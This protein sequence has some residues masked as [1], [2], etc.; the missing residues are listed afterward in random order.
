MNPWIAYRVPPLTA[1][2][3][4][5]FT[6]PYA[7]GGAS[8]YRDWTR[9]LPG[10]IDV[11]PVQLPGREMRIA[12]T[13]F[14]SMAPLVSALKDGISPLLDRPF[15]LFG[16]SMGASIALELARALNS[17]PATTSVPMT[18]LIVS[19]RICPGRPPKRPPIHR[20][21]DRDFIRELGGLGGTAAEVLSSTELMELMLPLLRADFAL[22]ETYRA[23]PMPKLS[24]PILALY[25]TRDSTTEV[26][27]MEGWKQITTGDARLEPIEGDHFYLMYAKAEVTRLVATFLA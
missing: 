24:V 15:A 6:L 3:L 23:G 2:R 20:L 10:D 11:C 9:Y 4:R 25:G 14:T 7:G 26:Q 16:H 12:E 8:V 21:Q 17:D 1:P 18:G 5:L 27:D 22:V 19:A 13:A